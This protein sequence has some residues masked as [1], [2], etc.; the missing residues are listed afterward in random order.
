MVSRATVG[1]RSCGIWRGTP[2]FPVHHVGRWG[3]HPQQPGAGEE[4][5]GGQKMLSVAVHPCLR[6]VGI[7]Q[8][9]NKQAV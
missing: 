8:G 2:H 1:R 3:R 7:I 4:P 9:E 6:T 5:V